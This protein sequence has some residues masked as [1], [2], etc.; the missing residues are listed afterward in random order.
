[1]RFKFGIRRR[2]IIFISL[3]ILLVAMIGFLLGYFS[4][5]DLLKNAVGSDYRKIADA[6]AFNVQQVINEKVSHIK[7]LM[8]DPAFKKALRESNSRYQEMLPADIQRFMADMDRQWVKAD[9]NSPVVKGYL[10]TDISRELRDKI[11]AGAEIAEVFIS[12]KYG[13]LVAASGKTIDFYQADESWWQDAFTGGGEIFIGDIESDGFGKTPG[14]VLVFPIKDGSGQIIGVAKAAVNIQCLFNFLEDFKFGYTGHVVLVD[15]KGYVISLKG[16]KPLSKKFLSDI[17][18]QKVIQS[19]TRIMIMGSQGAQPNR[20][21]S[22]FSEVRFSSLLK[23]GIIWK[24]FVEQDAKDVLWP[25]YRLTL[26]AVGVIVFLIILIPVFGFI[27]GSKISRPIEK[28]KEASDHITRGELD[29][30][31]RIKTGD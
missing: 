14:M 5:L 8:T 9:K 3:T 7:E 25:L 15:E 18:F 29:Y 21:L 2:I 4:T 27:L 22:A 6:L 16:T 13:G 20:I 26:Q 12:D 31:I 24:V 11:K 1:M 10:E 28:L 30:P 17:D 23:K 19:K